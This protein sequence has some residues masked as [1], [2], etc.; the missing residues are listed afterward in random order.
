MFVI[1]FFFIIIEIASSYI[2]LDM[3]GPYAMTTSQIFS[4]RPS[5]VGSYDVSFQQ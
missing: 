3:L 1:S 5:H 2:H 4:H